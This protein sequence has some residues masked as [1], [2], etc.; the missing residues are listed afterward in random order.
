MQP[1]FNQPL[2]AVLTLATTWLC[3]YQHASAN[4]WQWQINAGQLY[5]DYHEIDNQGITTDGVLNS[6]T[7]GIPRVSLSL[8]HEL[9]MRE[10][11]MDNL[12]GSNDSKVANTNTNTKIGWTPYAEVTLSYASGKTDYDGYLQSGSTLTP[13]NS[14]TNNR[15]VQTRLV[16]GASKAVA[17]TVVIKPHLA[18]SHHKWQREL[19]QYTEN[20]KHT[21]VLAGASLGWQPNQPLPLTLKATGQ[22]GKMVNSEIEVAKLGLKQN[23]GN[24]NIWRVGV[25]GSYHL[26]NAVSLNVG[27]NHERWQ[28]EQSA[29]Q[30]GYIY[31]ESK[32]SQFTSH[33]GINYSF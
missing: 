1:Y 29:K 14:T 16:F 12:N 8:V 6:E 30:N 25:N 22:V 7:G 4:S 3:C 33:L 13:Y 24:A 9:K 23:L 21:A 5:Q 26:T 19:E 18:A 32:T 20:F 31:P 10:L 17:N 11:K 15:I 27:V 2:C 28:Y